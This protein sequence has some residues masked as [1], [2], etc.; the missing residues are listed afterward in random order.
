MFVMTNVMF[1]AKVLPDIQH[2]RAIP[3]D[4]G[5]ICYLQVE[6][7]VGIKLFRKGVHQCGFSYLPGSAQHQRFAL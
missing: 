7:D 6:P 4:S 2:V 3:E 5:V 1:E